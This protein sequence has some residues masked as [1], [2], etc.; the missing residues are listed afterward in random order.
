MITMTGDMTF[1]EDGRRA[2]HR[3]FD[4]YEWATRFSAKWNGKPAWC[5]RDEN[6]C[7]CC[8]VP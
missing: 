8:R 5:C 3:D 6:A 1:L 7:E 2:L 4:D